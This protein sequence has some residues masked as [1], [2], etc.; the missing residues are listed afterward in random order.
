MSRY[1]HLLSKRYKI[2]NYKNLFS[3]ALVNRYWCRIIIP[4]LWNEPGYYFKDIRL[5][6][7]LLLTL[8]AEEQT[9][10]IPFKISL[11]SYSKP[12][13]EYTR[14]ITTVTSDLYDGIR[15]LLPCNEVYNWYQRYEI[16]NAVKY[17]LIAMLLRTSENLKYL[18]LD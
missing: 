6:K 11:P 10:L 7:I 9:L 18:Y 1:F 8:N 14:Y 15:N 16:E 13:F 2:S 3:C 4:I 5:I 17:S 12:L